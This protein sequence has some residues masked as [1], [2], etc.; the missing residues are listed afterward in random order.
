M[1]GTLLKVS[2]KCKVIF[3]VMRAFQKAREVGEEK[4]AKAKD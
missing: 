1:C 4:L 3:C 2:F